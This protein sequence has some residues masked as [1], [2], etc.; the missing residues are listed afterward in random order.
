MIAVAG[1]RAVHTLRF[2][3]A[4]AGTM[5]LA[6]APVD[7]RA[8]QET[9]ATAKVAAQA[10]PAGTPCPKGI[11][12]VAGRG[13]GLYA[14]DGKTLTLR[15]L[16]SQLRR[17]SATGAFE[18]VVIGGVKPASASEAA[19][20]VDELRS[21]DITHIEWADVALDELPLQTK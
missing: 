5:L 3:L 9:S 10:T 4:F 1:A 14:Y 2:A 19:R 17:A 16:A 20:I 18:C 8:Q 6:T 21:R 11:A 12:R 13:E 7:V 15:S